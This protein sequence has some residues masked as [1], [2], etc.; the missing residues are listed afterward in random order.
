MKR[1]TNGRHPVLV[2]PALL[3]ALALLPAAAQ[4]ASIHAFSATSITGEPVDLGRYR[5]DVVLVVNTASKC[6]FTYQFEGLQWLWETYRHEGLVVLGFPSDDFA[7]QEFATDAETLAFCT[8][9]YDVSFPMFSQVDVTGPGIHPLFAHLAAD[10]PV[11]WNFN[12]FLVDRNGRL[13]E[14]FDTPEEPDGPRMVAAIEAALA[15]E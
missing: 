6:G 7:G 9:E 3:C 15:T 1:G 4:E 8:G 14:R 2:L 10:R 13:I 11:S 12:K 5:G